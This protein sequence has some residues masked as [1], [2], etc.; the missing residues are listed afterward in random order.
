MSWFR[1]LQAMQR[2]RRMP[3]QDT[4][5]IPRMVPYGGEIHFTFTSYCPWAIKLKHR[6]LIVCQ[7][8][9][10]Y[11]LRHEWNLRTKGVE[12]GVHGDDSCLRSQQCQ[13]DLPMPK[14]LWMCTSR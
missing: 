1:W 8:D 5:P 14:F 7:L 11:S 2:L 4:E 10:T 6:P 13:A 12:Y 9:S 3:Q